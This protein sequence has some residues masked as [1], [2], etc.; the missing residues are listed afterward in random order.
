M[1]RKLD[2]PTL[3]LFAALLFGA[4]VRFWPALT[5]GFPLNDGGMFYT[6]ILDLKENNYQLP[7]FT[8]YNNADIP[9][10]Y[11]PFGFYIAALLS[12]L[13]P[14]SAL[15]ILLWLPALVN[16]LSIFFFYKLAGQVLNSRL[17]ASLAVL[18]YALSSRAFLWQVMGGGITRAFG[19]L[20]LILM[21]WQAVQLFKS[22][23]HP[24][25]LA[26]TIL[27]GAGAILSH[28]QTALHAVLGGAILFGF[29][30]RNKR[31]VLS[32]TAIGLGVVLLTAPWWGT[33]LLRHGFEPLLSAGQTSQRTLES[34]LAILDFS[35]LDDYVFL[36]AFLLA[37]VGAVAMFKKHEF[38]LIAWPLLALLA[39]PRGGEGIALL[40]LSMLA[41]TGLEKAANWLNRSKEGSSEDPLSNR[42]A[43]ALLFVLFTYLILG[44]MIFDF[45]LVNTSLKPADLEMI[46]W[47]KE[48]INERKTFLLSTGREF[49]MSDPMQEW[50]PALTSQ[51][52]VTTLQGLEWT[53]NELFFPWHSE[54]VAFQHCADLN[55][56]TN[57]SGKN[58]INYD[59]LLVTVPA[60]E[61]KSILA[62]SLRNLA[63]S[64]KASPSYT[65]VYE[66]D[67][68]LIFEFHR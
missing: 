31:G 7:E 20:F 59:Y 28:P 66:S 25:H 2:W 43:Q 33:V 60:S 6:M 57:W 1:N 68:T 44:A 15:Q 53:L 4:I 12:D 42:K 18:I 62:D 55:C 3:V 14:V 13:L 46:Q 22:E 58:K 50:F 64:A 24:T 65:V 23:G 9:F 27:F 5:N 11:P 30:G 37:V 67:S 8:E 52:S 41:G 45:Q 63:L 17:L 38:L 16:T 36:P 26:L 21:L 35:G 29:Y 32:V 40:P 19:M 48:N 39:D 51:Y 54:L 10:A 61:D 34:Y 47:V 49:S 56:V